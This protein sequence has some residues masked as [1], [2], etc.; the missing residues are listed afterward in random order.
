MTTN[1]RSRIICL[2]IALTV[3]FAML[4]MATFAETA[5]NLY[6]NGEQITDEKLEIVCGSGSATYDSAASNLT[7]N[8]AAI[9]QSETTNKYGIRMP[10]KK[11]LTITLEG[12]NS[13]VLPDGGGIMTNGDIVITGEGK[14]VI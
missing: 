1:K 14:L 2:L 8:N 12:T 4:P 11:K 3:M 7:L 6:V 10:E 5:Y 9:T 13:I